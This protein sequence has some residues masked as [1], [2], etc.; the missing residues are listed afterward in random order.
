V[1]YRKL[2]SLLEIRGSLSDIEL[3]V[4]KELTSIRT[5]NLD[6]NNMKG[7][8]HS[9]GIQW[10]SNINYFVQTVYFNQSSLFVENSTV[11]LTNQTI[12]MLEKGSVSAKKKLVSNSLLVF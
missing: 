3:D 6:L 4:F 7:F 10:M 11:K 5:I 1:V 2:I 9:R 8:V 12:S